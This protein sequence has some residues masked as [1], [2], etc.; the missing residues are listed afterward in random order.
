MR[1]LIIYVSIHH[2]NTEKI[3]RV[4]EEVLNAGL[5]KPDEVNIN[6]LSEYDL[7]GFASGIYMG[8]HHKSLL[9]VIDKLP[10]LKGRK[11]FVFSTSGESNAANFI[12]NIRHKIFH[13]HSPLRKRLLK[14]GFEIIGEFSCRGFDTFGSF[15]L[16]G[17]MNKNSPDE[18][19]VTQ[20]R[21]FDKVLKEKRRY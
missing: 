12:H 3:A 19:D 16:M 13:F 10:D 5:V 14:K 21:K 11:A 2:N 1:T 7:I 15:K 6:K 20:V 17:G 8:E 9:N 18:K 4:M